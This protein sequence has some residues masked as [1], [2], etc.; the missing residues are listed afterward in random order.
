MKKEKPYEEPL[1]DD[2]TLVISVSGGKDSAAMCI[3]FLKEANLPNPLKF[4]FADTGWE[5]QDTLT[6]VDYLAETLGIEIT[7][8]RHELDFVELS[9]KWGYFPS[10]TARFCTDYLKVKPI[11]EYVSR[12]IDEEGL[13]PVMVVGIRAEESSRRALMT[14][15]AY[16][17]AYDCPMWRPFMK[18]T[19][20]EVF[21]IHK[22]YD[23]KPNP[24][25]LRGAARVGCYPCIMSRK[26]EIADALKEGDGMIEKIRLAEARVSKCS[27]NGVSTFFPPNKT[28]EKYHDIEYTTSEG[29]VVT[30]ASIDAIRLWALDGDQPELDMGEAPSCFSQY[31]LCE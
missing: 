8:V 5:H 11:E 29:K 3:H 12:L 26:G 27:K 10:N 2:Q 7:T 30:T 22:K 1:R 18:W 9:E 4:V 20:E 24:L 19:S 16:S 21:A 23:V 15:W 13:D 6:Y 17:Q 28:P 25:Y 14:E 31:G